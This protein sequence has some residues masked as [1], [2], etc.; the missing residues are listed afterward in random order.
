MPLL[1]ENRVIQSLWIGSSL[2][3]MEQ[4]G[5][6]SHIAHGHEFHLYVYDAIQ[7]VPR[8]ATLKD[9]AEILPASRIFM[10]Q[11]DYDQSLRELDEGAAIEPEHPMIK[12][13]RARVLS[14]R[15]AFAES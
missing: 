7:N 4:L 14:Y 8:G 9:A 13:I 11:G 2:S 12:V 5:I 10:Y 1:P 6:A 3:A 15:G